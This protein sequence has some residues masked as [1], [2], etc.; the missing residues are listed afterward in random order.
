[1]DDFQ[2]EVSDT[3]GGSPLIDPYDDGLLDLAEP[4]D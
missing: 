4:A 1:M 3:P 2:I